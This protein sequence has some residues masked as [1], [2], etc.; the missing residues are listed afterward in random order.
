MT[1]SS[2]RIA[3]AELAQGRTQDEYIALV[4][5]QRYPNSS[6]AA[7]PSWPFKHSCGEQFS[8]LRKIK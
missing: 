5:A 2:A 1:E 4:W 6:S 8:K 3:L 7:S